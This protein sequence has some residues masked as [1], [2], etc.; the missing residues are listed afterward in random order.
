ML[1]KESISI[2]SDLLNMLVGEDADA[3]KSNVD[4]FVTLFNESIDAEV[5]KRIAGKTPRTGGKA[6][7]T[8]EEIYKV[9]D[10][11]ERR[12]LIAENSNL[13]E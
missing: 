1:S 6:T 5:K 7:I 9:K 2:S 11:A 3:T 10:G 13:F 12:R 8:K 4:S